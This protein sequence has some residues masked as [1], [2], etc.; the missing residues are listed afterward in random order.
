M[1]IYAENLGPVLG[2]NFSEASRERCASEQILHVLSHLG[3]DETV[4][5]SGSCSLGSLVD[6]DPLCSL[7][8]TIVIV[9][10]D[11]VGCH[12]NLL[13]RTALALLPG[14]LSVAGGLRW[15]RM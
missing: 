4:L 3:V 14:R 6:A 12:R 7:S 15:C 10:G 9:L 8:E 5:L 2:V 11:E 1:G 13:L